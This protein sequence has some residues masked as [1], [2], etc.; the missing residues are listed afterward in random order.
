MKMKLGCCRTAGLLAVMCLTGSGSLMAQA[1]RDD[2]VL[3]EIIVTASKRGE[4]SVQEVAGGIRAMTG[5]FIENYN[6]RSFE[7]I[8]RM[9]PSLQFS[10]LAD[11]DLQPII[12]GIQSPGA[13]T[14]GV[15]FDETIIT[16]ANFNDGGGRTPDLGAYDIERVEILK[17]PQGTLFGASSMTGTVRFISNKPDASGFD[18]Y[19]RA[20]GNTIEDGD[21]SYSFDGM[22]NLPAVEDVL[23]FRGVAWYESRGGF[24]DHYAGLNGVTET[25]DANEVERTGFR[26]MGR[27]TPNEQFTVDAFVMKQDFETDGPPGFSEVPTGA[28]VPIEIIAGPPFLV[29]RT[30][31]AQAGTFGERIITT[32]AV[33]TNRNEVLLFGLTAEYDLG[34]GSVTATASQF[35]LDNFSGTDTSGVATTFGLVDVGYFFGTGQVR[36]ANPFLL[37]QNQDR[38]LKS[39]ELRF[40]SD[41]DGP[42]N[43]VAGVF[44]QEDSMQTET[45]V[46]LTDPVS[47]LGL[48][49]EHPQCIADPASAAAHSIVFGTDQW[50]DLES[51]A[52]F[53]HADFEMNDQWTLGAGI[54]YYDADERDR[55]FTLQAFQGSIPFTFPPA[56]GGPVQTVPILG[57]DDESSESET[58]WDASLSYQQTDDVMYYFRAATGFRDG[59][60]N[61]SNAAAQLGASIPTTFDP[62]TVLS[63]EIGAKTSWLEDRV[64]LNATYFW[65]NWE[66]IQVPGQDPTGSINFVANA[67]EAEIDGVELEIF[68]RPT[69]QWLLTFGLTWL[70]AELTKDQEI[71]DPDSYTTLPPLGLDGDPIPKAPEWAFSGSA[72]YTMPFGS[73]G[74]TDLS[75]RANFSYTGDSYRFFNDS[76]QGNAE[77]GDYFLMNLSANLIRDNWVFTLFCNNVTD[78]APT[79]DIFGNGTDAQHIITAEPRSIGAQVRWGFK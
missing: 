9:E 64:I 31:P 53:G 20:V 58:T 55:F 2:T 16:G 67:A 13:G 17:G 46:V 7:D 47:G 43:F 45:L 4:V 44:Y 11:S 23:A 21:P 52:F 28:N 49:D 14:V 40:S 26:L 48:C 27:F 61:D 18:A 33:E 78:E 65:M 34:F 3:E 50:R 6:L 68:A 32:G 71:D 25:K 22:I 29:G 35:D 37:A 76:F 30:A 12:R 66:D 42:V 60:I 41:L 74:N 8:A 10:K 54:R 70:N 77:I 39:A 62:D 79:I 15:Y 69:N 5:E 24:I 19:L 36:I 63:M 59:G 57:L 38:D 75:L 56:F 51:W 73:A 1:G 72:E